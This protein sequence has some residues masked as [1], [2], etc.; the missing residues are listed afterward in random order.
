M[1]IYFVNIF[2]VSLVDT[3]ITVIFFFFLWGNYN[4]PISKTA[5]NCIIRIYLLPLMKIYSTDFTSSKTY[6]YKSIV[7][8]LL[9]LI[10]NTFFKFFQTN[11]LFPDD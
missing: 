6:Q 4:T 10:Q 3:I 8:T 1:T 5:D 2:L 7:F 11:R 9:R